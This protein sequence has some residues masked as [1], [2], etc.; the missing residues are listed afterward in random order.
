MPSFQFKSRIYSYTRAI[1]MLKKW[2]L[3]WDSAAES[4]FNPH[5]LHTVASSRSICF[6]GQMSPLTARSWDGAPVQSRDAPRLWVHQNRENLPLSTNGPWCAWEVMLGKPCTNQLSI[7]PHAIYISQL[8]FNRRVNSFLA[9]LFHGLTL[10]NKCLE[11]L[12]VWECSTF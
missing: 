8:I 1:V 9:S 4:A 7:P 10:F 6:S 12:L 2:Y 5:P 11:L 3:P